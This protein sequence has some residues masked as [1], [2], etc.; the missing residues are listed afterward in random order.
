MKLCKYYVF[1]IIIFLGTG[2]SI[3]KELEEKDIIDHQVLP[4]ALKWK[5]AI[6]KKDIKALV[7][8]ALPE[9]Q[10]AVND[11][12]ILTKSFLHRLFFDNESNLNG[13]KSVYEI[14]INSKNIKI[15]KHSQLWKNANSVSVYYYDQNKIDLKFP[16]NPD[17]EQLLLNIGLVWKTYFF[18]VDD[19]W[20]T[21][22]NYGQ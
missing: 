20:Y 1:I 12:L 9:D 18:Q 11:E 4:V 13:K 10:E 15:I 16:I 7:N 17:K 5:E 14:L 19:I 22:Y 6:L 8:F 2:S 3:C 21:S